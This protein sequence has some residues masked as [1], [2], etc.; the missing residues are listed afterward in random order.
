VRDASGIIAIPFDPRESTM[1]QLRSATFAGSARR[2]SLLAALALCAALPARAVEV[3]G[4]GQAAS[5]S[6]PIGAFEAIGLSGSI[7]LQLRQGSPTALVV[8][9]DANLLPLLET[10]VEGDQLKVRFKRGTSLRTNS[11][12]WVEVTAPQVHAIA[13]AGS[14]D[15]T[16]DAM[17]VPRLALSL[18][19]SGGVQAKALQS[20]ELS[21][22][23]AGSSA[24][25]LAGQ[26]ARVSI[27]VSGSGAIEA[28]E[29]RADDVKISIAGSGDASVNAVRN[30]TVSIAGSGNVTYSGEPTLQRAI[31]GSGTVRK[32]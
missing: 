28:A 10:V 15:I 18:H 24:V 20:D 17:K 26:V 4:N 12:A 29:L 11:R 30:L 21:L 22:G 27:N 19:G 2:G 25:K 6:R 5:E 1:M 8:H 23:L 31:A 3:I 32:R 9:A 16:I 7:G 14:G 13:N